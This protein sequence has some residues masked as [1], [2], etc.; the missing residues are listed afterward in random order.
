MVLNEIFV[1]EK[2]YIS[3]DI[4]T[5]MVSFQVRFEDWPLI[6]ESEAWKKI[7]DLLSGLKNKKEG[8]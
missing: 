8:E 5:V 4:I 6:Q 7:E 2:R 1:H 3:N